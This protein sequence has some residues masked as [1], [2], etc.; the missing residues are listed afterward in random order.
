MAAEGFEWWIARIRRMLQLA[1]VFR[2]DHF[3]GFAGY[4]E[5]P[6]DQPTA[7]HGSWV[8][9]PGQAMFEAIERALGRLPIIA[10]DLGL[11]TPDVIALRDAF[12]FPGMKIVQF[13]FG[14]DASEP[15]LPHHH[16]PHCVAYT[17]THDNHTALGWWDTAASRER[18][19]AALY[20]GATRETIVADLM[21]A[22]WTSVANLAVAQFQDVLG[23][24]AGHRMNLP[25]STQGNWAWR[26]DWP[27][28][29]EQAARDLKRLTAAT[30]RAPFALAGIGE[31]VTR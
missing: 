4:Y 21:R 8:P 22:T 30:G 9:A 27:M 6:A 24:D 31:A 7:E 18:E 19:Y 2:I 20:L 1:D 12:G 17:G 16:V 5:I 25:G 14:G 28:V 23:L 15:F 13:A 11:I 29:S 26:F 3:R 10:E